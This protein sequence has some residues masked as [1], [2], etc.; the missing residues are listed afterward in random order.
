[1]SKIITLHDFCIGRNVYVNPEYIVCV[2]SY[3]N[4]TQILLV[5]TFVE[6]RES[7]EEV[8]SIINDAKVD[9]NGL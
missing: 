2:R 9:S 7:P 5:S 4:R 3:S 6:V 1:M 8:M